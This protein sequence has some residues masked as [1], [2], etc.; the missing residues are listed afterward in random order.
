MAARGDGN[1]RQPSGSRAFSRRALPICNAS[2][3]LIRAPGRLP[4]RVP[5]S[6]PE[7]LDL[8][9]AAVAIGQLDRHELSRGRQLQIGLRVGGNRA[10]VPEIAGRHFQ[11]PVRHRAVDADA[12]LADRAA[13][14]HQLR[15]VD[16]QPVELAKRQP[17]GCGHV[18]DLSLLVN[19]RR[20]GVELD[21]K[22]SLQFA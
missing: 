19:Q 16:Q 3:S 2:G 20:L 11:H 1:P 5:H 12:H 14:R 9:D 7:A 21:R 22:R 8:R 13:V 10:G 6:A 18:E 17:A 15:V 4:G